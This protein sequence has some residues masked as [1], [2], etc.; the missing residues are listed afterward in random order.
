[1]MLERTQIVALKGHRS[2]RYRQ[3]RNEIIQRLGTIWLDERKDPIADLRQ[4]TQF[5]C[6]RGFVRGFRG[7]NFRWHQLAGGLPPVLAVKLVYSLTYRHT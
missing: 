6:W 1:M 5:P 3:M 7:G 4:S 2:E